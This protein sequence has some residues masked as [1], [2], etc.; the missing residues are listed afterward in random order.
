MSTL[1]LTPLLDTRFGVGQVTSRIGLQAEAIT[2]SSDDNLLELVRQT[3]EAGALHC[4]LVDESQFLTQGQVFHLGEVA[5]R[6]DI[7]VIAYGLRTDFQGNLFEGSQHLLAWADTIN[8]IKTICH[9][10]R[11]ATMVLRLDGN[12]KALRGGSQVQIGGNETYMSVCRL[13]FKEGLATREAEQMVFP[14]LVEED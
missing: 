5:D 7:P 4:V 12:G 1:V 6:M 13:H 2:F 9:C 3:H 11:K 8:E 14:E 10:G